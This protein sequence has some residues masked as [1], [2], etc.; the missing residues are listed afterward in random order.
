MSFPTEIT[1]TNGTDDNV[2]STI[3]IQD[4][5]TVRRDASRGLVLPLIMRISTQESGSGVNR[6]SRH[7][8]RLDSTSNYDDDDPAAKATRSVYFNVI[9]PQVFAD[10][11]E[12]LIMIDQLKDFLSAANIA[13]LLNG[14]S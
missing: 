5:T 10:N 12:L 2:V 6:S 1:L 8:V 7:L 3:S 11:S 14:E 9:N 13:K 4:S